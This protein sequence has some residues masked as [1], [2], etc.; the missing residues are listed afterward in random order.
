MRDAWFALIL[1]ALPL[2]VGGCVVVDAV[3]EGLV[4]APSAEVLG[5]S[6][7]DVGERSAALEAAVRL[8]N[9]N[10]VE[11]PVE[12]VRVRMVGP[13]GESFA[14][15]VP[16]TVSMPP[17]G[18]E[19]MQVRGVLPTGNGDVVGEQ[20]RVSVTVRWVP[21]GEVRAILTETGVPL[22]FVVARQSGGEGVV[23]DVEG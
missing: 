8:S 21:P 10:D 6:V 15:A 9:P 3:Q 11:L 20:V 1:L 13:G 5:V 23:G 4:D 14:S 7:V 2:W 16:V 19:V 22:P 12:S 17:N 18:S